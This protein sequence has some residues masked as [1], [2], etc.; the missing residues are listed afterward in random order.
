MGV[1]ALKALFAQMNRERFLTQA[2][3]VMHRTA[4]ASLQALAAELLEEAQMA[5]HLF[6][7]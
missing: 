1:K 6:Q 4:A 2:V 7:R 5:Q 3:R